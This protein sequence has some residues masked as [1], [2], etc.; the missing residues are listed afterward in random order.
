[1]QMALAAVF[2]C[3]IDGLGS[4]NRS[5]WKSNLIYVHACE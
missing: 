2:E 4:R 1:L 3:W 5:C